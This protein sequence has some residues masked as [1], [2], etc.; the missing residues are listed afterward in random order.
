MESFLC[1]SLKMNDTLFLMFFFFFVIFFLMVVYFI[2]RNHNYYGKDLYV[3]FIRTIL[4]CYRLQHFKFLLECSLI[5]RWFT[6]VNMKFNA[7]WHR[8]C[9]N[10]LLILCSTQLCGMKKW[11]E[12]KRE[13]SRKVVFLYLNWLDLLL[14]VCDVNYSK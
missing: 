2:I 5:F 4:I 8:V 7:S 10:C 3:F 11:K 9:F 14:T 1:L 12:R 6:S 13:L